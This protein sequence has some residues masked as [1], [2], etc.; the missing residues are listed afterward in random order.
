MAEVQ[1]S[2][3]LVHI[4]FDGYVPPSESAAHQAG[5]S[6]VIDGDTIKVGGQRWR[7]YGVDAPPIAGSSHGNPHCSKEEALG[8]AAKI[9]LESLIVQGVR[10]GTLRFDIRHLQDKHRRHLVSITVDGIDVA[11]TLQQQGVAKPY[12]GKGPK[13][14]FCDCV[15]AQ[16]RHHAEQ[17]DHERHLLEQAQRKRHPTR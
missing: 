6:Y 11:D 3:G 17:L 5:N 9:L 2:G 12:D 1:T 13:P 7:L 10:N 8:R 15:T 16:I 14:I 4:H